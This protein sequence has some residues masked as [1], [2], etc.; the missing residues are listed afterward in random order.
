M[1]MKNENGYFSL[2][3]PE[4]DFVQLHWFLTDEAWRSLAA[5]CTCD[6]YD[7]PRLFLT[8]Y[9]LHNDKKYPLQEHD[10]FGKKNTW[11]LSIDDTLGGSKIEF[12]L[13]GR[14]H[15]HGERVHIFTSQPIHVPLRPEEVTSKLEGSVTGN[16][17]DSAG[18]ESTG[19]DASNYRISS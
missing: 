19:R 2:H 7:E 14:D 13:F 11:I 12:E 1:E 8:V 4:K 6:D 3:M 15:T 10:V 16:I 5:R 9:S 18:I 17:M